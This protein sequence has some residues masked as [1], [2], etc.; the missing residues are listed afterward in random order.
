MYSLLI[1]VKLDKQMNTEE[2]VKLLLVSVQGVKS[3]L[4]D[5]IDDNLIKASLYNKSDT[6]FASITVK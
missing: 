3:S 2:I 5:Y 1:E 6:S 4:S